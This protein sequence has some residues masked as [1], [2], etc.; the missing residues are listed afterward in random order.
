MASVIVDSVQGLYAGSMSADAVAKTI[1][2]SA[3]SELKK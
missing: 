3:A 2:E 1:E